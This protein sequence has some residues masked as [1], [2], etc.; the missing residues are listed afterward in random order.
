MNLQEKIYEDYLKSCQEFYNKNVNLLDET[1]PGW[2]TDENLIY[3]K[4]LTNYRCTV[5]SLN[6]LKIQNSSMEI[7][8]GKDAYAFLDY[9][10]EHNQETSI[11]NRI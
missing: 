2:K 10:L 5:L 8:E 11:Y 7:C 1:N 4:A 9:C 6:P 3:L